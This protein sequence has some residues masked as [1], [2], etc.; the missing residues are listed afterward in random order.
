M[1]H[2]T[3]E[4]AVGDTNWADVSVSDGSYHAIDLGTIDAGKELE[5][6]YSADD[7]IDILFM[8][9]NSDDSSQLRLDLEFLDLSF[10][11]KI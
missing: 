6:D 10:S 1:L 5:I 9:S 8:N 4:N 7:N 3:T 11:Q 2:F